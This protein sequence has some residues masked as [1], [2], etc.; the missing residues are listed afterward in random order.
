M[1]RFKQ[2]LV[3]GFVRPQFGIN[4]PTRI[5]S[6]IKDKPLSI[7]TQSAGYGRDWGI[8]RGY[9]PRGDALVHTT[10]FFPE[11]GV[12]KTRGYAES[13]IPIENWGV[14]PLSGRETIHFTRNGLVSSHLSGNW[15]GMPFTIIAPQG[16]MTQRL[17]A[18]ADQDSWVLGNVEVP[19]GSTILVNE[20]TLTPQHKENLAKMFGVDNYEQ[21]QQRLQK[22]S[23]LDFD[24]RQIEIKFTKGDVKKAVEAQLRNVGIEPIN[25][26]SDYAVGPVDRR[27]FSKIPKRFGLSY[28]FSD[29]AT[30]LFNKTTKERLAALKSPFRLSPHESSGFL[31]AEKMATPPIVFARQNPSIDWKV[32]DQ[33]LEDLVV[34]RIKSMGRNLHPEE[35]AALERNKNWRENLQQWIN[36]K[37]EEYSTDPE[38][39]ERNIRAGEK[40]YRT[41][42]ATEVF[43]TETESPKPIKIKTTA[44]ST[45]KPSIQNKILQTGLKAANVLDPI[46]EVAAQ[47]LPRAAMAAGMGPELAMTGG[48]VPLAVMGLTDTA[49]DPMGDWKA[50]FAPGEYENWVDEE[51]KRRARQ[52]QAFIDRPYNPESR[53]AN[54]RQ[55]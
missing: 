10:E 50:G 19:H 54:Q 31:S 51:K 1:L 45:T 20:P 18:H 22:G 8:D 29:A 47:V 4:E 36:I 41:P 49:G 26:G 27:P 24:G 21:I 15:E 6:P 7:F 5:Q 55:R 52:V 35:V 46:P 40:Q 30:E 11:G 42:V 48:M 39:F 34:P 12:I 23:N 32:P 2:F 33:T 43:G 37:Q 44:T 28:G 16:P 3:E 14:G 17:M 53:T 9:N 38:A 25:I 13:N